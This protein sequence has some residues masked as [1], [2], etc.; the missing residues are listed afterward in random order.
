VHTGVIPWQV[1]AFLSALFAALTAVLA[2]VG[3]EE[4]DPDFATFIRTI[5]IVLVLGCL[6]AISGQRPTEIS[7]RSLGFLTLSGLA[8]G[9]S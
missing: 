5:V 1:W 3:V 7:P 2:K 4:I 6:L 8:T 9:A